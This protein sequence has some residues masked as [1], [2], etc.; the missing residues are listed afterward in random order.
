MPLVTLPVPAWMLPA[1]M[2]AMC[3]AMHCVRHAAQHPGR[4]AAWLLCWP[5][6]R[7][8]VQPPTDLALAHVEAVV[9]TQHLQQAAGA[10]QRSAE[11]AGHKP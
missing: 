7:A 11:A 9:D 8:A 4:Q 1:W 10:V 5:G 6:Q 2:V 3:C